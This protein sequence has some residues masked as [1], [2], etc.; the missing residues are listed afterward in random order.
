M[1]HNFKV[2][3]I[4]AG[5]A[6]TFAAYELHKQLGDHIDF[7]VYERK[8]HA[9]GRA[10]DVDFAGTH[11][12]VGGVLLHSSGKYGYE[13]MDY[14]GSKEGTPGVSVDGSEETYAFWTSEGFPVFTKTSLASMALG[15]LR[16]V[17]PR[18]AL[19]VTNAAKDM[20]KKMEDIYDFQERGQRFRTTEDILEAC[21][22]L[23]ETRKDLATYLASKGV[24]NRMATDIV[25]P[26]VHN[27]YNQGLELNAFAGLVGLAGAGLAG[28]YLFSVAG[29]NW[30]LFQKALEKMAVDLRLSCTVE[31][32]DI[33]RDA[34]GVPTFTVEAN[35][36]TADT[37]D[38]VI[39]AA[40]PALSHIAVTEDGQEVPIARNP[41]QPVHTT[42][43]V[44]DLNPAYFGAP[45]DKKLPSTIFTADSASAPFK[46]VGVTGYSPVHH[47]RIYKIFSAEHKMTEAELSEIF[48][49]VADVHEHVWAGAYPVL[50]TRVSHVPFEIKP[51]LYFANAFETAAGSIE[52]EAVGGVNAA[53]LAADY[54]TETALRAWPGRG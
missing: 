21:G 32:V 27:M 4:G 49:D 28:G 50:N 33:T 14:T 40:P 6:G 18:S 51:G 34:E 43:V 44:G 24:N 10:W 29:G 25:E 11:V 13:L 1:S 48:L 3:V 20:A 19:V 39:L 38:L 53:H 42:L 12:E 5:S 9:G 22:L 17:G 37:Y 45:A 54:L 36:G 35:D 16:Y 7:T 52:V 26:I 15:I 30:T 2:A 46:S 23:A 47:R 41:Y 8:E 31:R